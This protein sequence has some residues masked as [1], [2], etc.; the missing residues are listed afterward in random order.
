MEVPLYIGDSPN[1]SMVKIRA[2]C[3][4]LKQ[5][6]ELSLASVDYLPLMSSGKK[7]ASRRQEGV[8][9]GR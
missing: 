7:A 3:R 6:R 2:K 5:K 8:L 1:M 4:R 9:S